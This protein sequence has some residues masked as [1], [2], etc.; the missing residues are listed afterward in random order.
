M[1]VN[2]E[3]RAG[4]RARRSPQLAAPSRR[5]LRLRCVV[6]GAGALVRES[7]N[8]YPKEVTLTPVLMLVARRSWL[9]RPVARC[10]AG[11]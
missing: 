8:A 4:R 7:I 6:P 3:P 2:R 9:L 10:P 5:A 11:A 1:E